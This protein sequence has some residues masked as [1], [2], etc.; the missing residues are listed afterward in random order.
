LQSKLSIA[1]R[2][3]LTRYVH[4]LYLNDQVTYYRVLNLDDR[5]EGVDQYI[6]TDVA[7]FCDSLAGLYSNLGKPI[8]DT[9]IFNYQ[10]MRSIGVSGMGGLFVSYVVTA[11]LLRMVTPAFG[12]LAAVEAK[13]EVRYFFF[14][15]YQLAPWLHLC[16]IN[17]PIN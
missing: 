11:F 2:T 6:T 3:R 12:K 8:L 9:I 15:L 4:D 1:F 17:D 16:S 10:L 7:K 5:I 14:I 13:L